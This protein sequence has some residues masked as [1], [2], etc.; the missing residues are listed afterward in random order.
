MGIKNIKHINTPT[1]T[2]NILLEITYNY[3]IFATVSLAAFVMLI[4]YKVGRIIFINDQRIIFSTI[5]ALY[6]SILVALI[7][8]MT[9][10]TYYDGK[11]SILIWILLSSLRCFLLETNSIKK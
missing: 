3:G 4:I 8:N 1:H 6:S 9:D 2:H 5:K 10:V 7:F 11:I